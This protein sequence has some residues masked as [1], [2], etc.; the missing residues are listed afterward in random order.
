MWRIP[1]FL[2]LFRRPR[3]IVTRPGEV[4][5]LSSGRVYAVYPGCLKALPI[6][7]IGQE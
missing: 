1:K 2:N 4:I 6:K 3:V 7:K 5:I